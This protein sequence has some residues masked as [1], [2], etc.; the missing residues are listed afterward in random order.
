MTQKDHL[1]EQKFRRNF[2]DTVDP[3]YSCSLETE[4]TDHFFYAVKIMCHFAQPL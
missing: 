1:R 3:L 2:A 4:S